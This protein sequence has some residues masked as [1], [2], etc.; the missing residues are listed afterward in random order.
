MGDNKSNEQ[1]ACEYEERD[2]API[3]PLDIVSTLTSQYDTFRHPQH[4][5]DHHTRYQYEYCS[6]G[7]VY[8]RQ[9][10]L[11]GELGCL[12]V[13]DLEDVPDGDRSHG[14]ER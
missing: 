8:L 4:E 3:A 1:W 9:P 13:G 11:Q 12:S 2:Y 14:T 5:S 10:L 7:S 6:A